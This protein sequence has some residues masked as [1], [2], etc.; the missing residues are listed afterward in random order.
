MAS[1]FNMNRYAIFLLSVT[2]AFATID[3]GRADLCINT[4]KSHRLTY[5]KD[6]SFLIR[7]GFIDEVMSAE[8]S[9]MKGWRERSQKW[10][11]YPSPEGGNDTIAYGHKLTD[12]D[13]R[14]RRFEHGISEAQAQYLLISD[15][16]QSLERM[17]IDAIH[18]NK[19]SWRQQWLLLDFQFN[20]GDVFKK[21][22]KFSDAVLRADTRTMLNE[23]K[24]YYRDANGK[25]HEVKDRNVRTLKFIKENL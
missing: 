23:Y 24:R 11:P 10:F 8:N 5:E 21:F 1:T 22:P 20:L 19:L 7:Q 25:R 16:Q 9:V 13:V 4:I 17:S 14:S 3:G 15:I 6:W 12:E 2:S 18:W